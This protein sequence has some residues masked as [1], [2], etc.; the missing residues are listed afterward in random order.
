MGTCICRQSA[1]NSIRSGVSARR[2]RMYTPYVCDTFDP[3][4]QSKLG[5]SAG[6]D[7]HGRTVIVAVAV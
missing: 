1:I 4:V 3:S 6:V 5:L 2:R 7:G